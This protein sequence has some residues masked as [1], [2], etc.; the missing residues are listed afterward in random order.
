MGWAFRQ[1]VP[2]KPKIVLLALSDQAEE[3]TGRVCYGKTDLT[4][5]ARKCSIPERSLSRYIGALIRNGYVS[6][7]S[8][9]EQGKASTYWLCLD[10]LPASDYEEW[11]WK[12]D[13]EESSTN[14][15]D[16]NPE[17]VGAPPVADPPEVPE[18][19]LPG[20]PIGGPARLSGLTKEHPRDRNT[21]PYGFSRKA[22]DLERGVGEK[23]SPK[24]EKKQAF[25]IENSR[26]WDAWDRYL[27]S[28]RRPGMFMTCWGQGEH[29]RKR[30]WPMPTLFPPSSTDPPA[31]AEDL[32]E[33]AIV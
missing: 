26:A 4:H 9:K 30:G 12:A 23:E 7:A 5:F 28:Q 20:R 31:P 6:R 24:E 8:G 33:I 29:A 19:G 3:T 22:Q 2:P 21:A 17:V 11:Q 18:N 25:V 27:R 14:E 10:R 32:G 15:E 1:M 16:E 13:A